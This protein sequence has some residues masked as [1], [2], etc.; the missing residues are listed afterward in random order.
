M[1][2]RHVFL[3]YMLRHVMMGWIQHSSIYCQMRVGSYGYVPL[4]PVPKVAAPQG[5]RA[6]NAYPLREAPGR[7]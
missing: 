1:A 2:L 7:V 6:G 5:P 3:V 4:C